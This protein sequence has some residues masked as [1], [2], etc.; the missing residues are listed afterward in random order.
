MSLVE[1]RVFVGNLTRTSTGEPAEKN[2]CCESNNNFIEIIIMAQFS[3][4]KIIVI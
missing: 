1:G 4:W 3:R 2:K